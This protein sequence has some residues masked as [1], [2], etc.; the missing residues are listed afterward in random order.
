LPLTRS[1]ELSPELGMRHRAGLGITE[2]SDAYAIIVSDETGII[3]VAHDGRMNRFLDVKILEKA[4]LDI[5]L[6]DYEPIQ[7]GIFRAFEKGG[8]G[9]KKQ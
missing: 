1:R 2:I 6:S 8:W 9:V 5:S 3:S 7:K 4:L